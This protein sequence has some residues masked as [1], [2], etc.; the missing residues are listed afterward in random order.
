[1]DLTEL[2]TFQSHLN[3]A[4]L[5]GNCDACYICAGCVLDVYWMCTGC[6]LD[7]YWICIGCVLDL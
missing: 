3:I 5:S 4:S 2:S 1:M 6:V 7:V